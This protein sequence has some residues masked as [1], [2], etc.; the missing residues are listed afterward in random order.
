[1]AGGLGAA[2]FEPTGRLSCVPATFNR[3]QGSVSTRR[4]AASN[5]GELCGNVIPVSLSPSLFL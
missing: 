4:L 5:V 2:S 1:M 3:I